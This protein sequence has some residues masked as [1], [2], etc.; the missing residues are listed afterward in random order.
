M[1]DAQGP[2]ATADKTTAVA[3]LAKMR[4]AQAHADGTLP[5]L[6]RKQRKDPCL[7]ALHAALKLATGAPTKRNLYTAKRQVKKA[8]QCQ[9][10]EQKHKIWQNKMKVR[11]A[12]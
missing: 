6:S 10:R 11:N 7:V 3:M 8:T 1:R 5:G 2:H 12:A 4:V 9:S